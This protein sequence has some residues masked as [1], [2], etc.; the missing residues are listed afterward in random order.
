MIEEL[1][2]IERYAYRDSIIHRLDARV[3]IIVA[4]AAII[5]MVS[6]PYSP[7]VFTVGVVFFIFFAILWILTRLVTNGIH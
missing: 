7:I 6:I 1:F 5:A 2:D 3:K 4:F